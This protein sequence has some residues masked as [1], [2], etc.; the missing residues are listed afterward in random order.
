MIANATIKSL[1]SSVAVMLA[2]SVIFAF[3]MC[4]SLTFEVGSDPIIYD[5][6]EAE[7]FLS[8]L[9]IVSALLAIF[10]LVSAG[11]VGRGILQLRREAAESRHTTFR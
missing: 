3:V 1:W 11:F 4:Y 5:P 9:S 2:A 10:F 6:E 8:K 7:G